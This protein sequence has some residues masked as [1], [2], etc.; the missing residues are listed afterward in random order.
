MAR[1]A[2]NLVEAAEEV[3][4]PG[5]TAA[6]D[7]D[8]LWAGGGFIGVFREG[9][10]RWSRSIARRRV[11]G[12]TGVPWPFR[13]SF[14]WGVFP[15]WLRDWWPPWSRRCIFASLGTS[16][17]WMGQPIPC[18]SACSVFRAGMRSWVGPL[19]LR[20]RF[21]E[22]FG[23]SGCWR[24]RPWLIAASSFGCFPRNCWG[25]AGHIRRRVAAIGCSRRLGPSCSCT[26]F[27]SSG[28]LGS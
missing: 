4:S 3:G 25:G 20:W 2:G 23:S 27:W 22:T 13:C 5:F 19:G 8:F 7:G 17:D 1:G 12:G 18:F 28:S 9:A 15:R 16:G 26:R 24:F 21:L 10:G 14:S 11:G 6:F